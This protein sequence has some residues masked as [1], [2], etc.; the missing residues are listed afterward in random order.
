VNTLHGLVLED[1][2]GHQVQIFLIAEVTSLLR[3]SMVSHP[4]RRLAAVKR[5]S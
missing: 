1:S 5:N 3:K 4:A 2:A